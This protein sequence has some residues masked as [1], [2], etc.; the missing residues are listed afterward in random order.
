[1]PA[2]AFPYIAIP[3]TTYG[4]LTIGG[5]SM[6]TYGWNILELRDLWI[7]TA[8]R[9]ADRLIPGVA[10]L[11]P[12]PRRRTATPHSLPMTITGLSDSVGNVITDPQAQ[13]NQLETHIAYLMDNV[14]APTGTATGTRDAVLTMPSGATRTAA[15]HVLSI[16]P[17]TYNPIG[18]RA[19][20]DIS[21]PAGRFA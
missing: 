3:S 6:H 10:G 19:T 4:A 11:R 15:I 18:L 12:K 21:I 13:R 9:G 1:M 8:V 7:V 16:T 5:I 14:V 17:G 2:V 20:L